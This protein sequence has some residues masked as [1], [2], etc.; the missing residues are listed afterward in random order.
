MTCDRCE[1]CF[2]SG[3]GFCRYCGAPLKRFGIEKIIFLAGC[4]IAVL[5]A[6][7]L[8]IEI[9]ALFA[10]IPNV[11]SNLPDYRY[12][13]FIIVPV[14]VTLFTAS[15]TALQAVYLMLIAAVAVSVF[16]LIKK[17]IKP[18]VEK[19]TEKFKETPFFKMVTLFAALYFLE[20]AFTLIL[21][22]CGVQLDTLPE[23]P[24]WQWMFDLLNASVWEELITRVLF[25]GLPLFVI[26]LAMKKKQLW[27]CLLGGCGM[28]RTALVFIIFSAFIFGAGHLN[29]WGSWKFFT[30][31]AFGLIAGYLFCRCGL[32][33]TI[34]M[35]F[36]TD[37]IQAEGWLCNGFMVFTTIALIMVMLL[38]IPYAYKYIRDGIGY[39]KE[40]FG[41][42]KH[43]S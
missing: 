23:R 40:E 37:Y 28:S 6:V 32:Y 13:F 33:A 20:F 26:G 35:H 27:K 7:V 25:L 9:A 15:G 18:I 16:I 17:S 42:S 1:E 38:G 29:N 8:I 4:I 11:W 39:L 14:I 21:Q 2:R 41:K 19:D 10:G 24:T 3:D 22:I 30:T 12:Q 43:L 36:L 34:S 31:F 5:L